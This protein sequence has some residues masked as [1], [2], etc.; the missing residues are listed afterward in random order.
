MRLRRRW[1]RIKSERIVFEIVI[2]ACVLL[3]KTVLTI[4]HNLYT[5]I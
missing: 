3:V 5:I 1:A 2:Y 4:I